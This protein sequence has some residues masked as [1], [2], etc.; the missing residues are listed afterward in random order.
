MNQTEI[1]RRIFGEELAFYLKTG[2]LLGMSCGT[3]RK[4]PVS[5]CSRRR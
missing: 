2:R 3:D 4:S 5:A 1:S